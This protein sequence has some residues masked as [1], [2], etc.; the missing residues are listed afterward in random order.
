MIDKDRTMRQPVLSDFKGRRHQHE[1]CIEEAL[2]VAERLCRHRRSRLT[3]LRRRVL[4]L[5]WQSHAPVKA[6][7]VLDA[8]RAER[9]GA[10]PPTVYRA[11]DFLRDEGLIHRLESLNAYVGCPAPAEGHSGQFLICRQ[12]QG[13]AELDDDDVLV[14]L[15]R[16]AEALGFRM[17]ST[18]IEIEGLCRHCQSS[19]AGC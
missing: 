2:D 16:D 1:R 8:L 17:L 9:A 14:G 12:C 18:T 4:E 19:S 10:A 6:Y 13:V 5:V 11:L 7:D 3:A 15:R